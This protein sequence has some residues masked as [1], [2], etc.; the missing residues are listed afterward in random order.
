MCVR[1]H[2]L[3]ADGHSDRSSTLPKLVLRLLHIMRHWE[4]KESFREMHYLITLRF[5][6]QKQEQFFR[7]IM[8]FMN[9]CGTRKVRSFHQYHLIQINLKGWFWK[10]MAKGR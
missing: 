9:C 2:S 1:C 10:K 5:S 6:V 7:C 8:F 4:R 3:V